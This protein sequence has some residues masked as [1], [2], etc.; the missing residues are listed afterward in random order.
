M[1]VWD[2][3]ID[4]TPQY[5]WTASSYTEQNPNYYLDRVLRKICNNEEL[6]NNEETSFQ[7]VDK[8]S[9]G[10]EDLYQRSISKILLNDNTSVDLH[11]L[12]LY[13][14]HAI[15]K[16]KFFKKMVDTI[17]FLENPLSFE[18]KNTCDKNISS[19]A[20]LN[21]VFLVYDICLACLKGA[22]NIPNPDIVRRIDGERVGFAFEFRTAFNKAFIIWLYNTGSEITVFVRGEKDR[23][24]KKHKVVRHS[25]ITDMLYN[26]FI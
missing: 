11:K 8:I 1:A 2:S 15:N 21:A 13:N 12:L 26:F 17:T 19:S 9:K 22:V 3:S 18:D 4:T 10:I 6:W 14:L 25:Y 5:S 7:V 24:Y 20:V 16:N 23:R